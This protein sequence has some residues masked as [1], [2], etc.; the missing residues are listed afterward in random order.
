MQ[1]FAVHCVFMASELVKTRRVPWF[2]GKPGVAFL[3]S[4]RPRGIWGIW[5]IWF[6]EDWRQAVWSDAA[7]LSTCA[8]PGAKAGILLSIPSRLP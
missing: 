5:G 6:G 7:R 1:M 2:L 8:V 3:L 4:A